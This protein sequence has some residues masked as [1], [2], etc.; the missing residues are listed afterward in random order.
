M[1]KLM[2]KDRLKNIFN[3]TDKKKLF[4]TTVILVSVLYK[5]IFAGGIGIFD[6]KYQVEESS[7]ESVTSEFV[8]KGDKG[9]D[10]TNKKG[11]SM[12]NANENEEIKKISV[13]I[14][15]AVANPGVISLDSD[16]RLDD[17]IRMAGGLLEKADINRI[18]LAVKLEDS[19]HYIIPYVGQDV[20]SAS[21]GPVTQ[22]DGKGNSASGENSKIN[23]N[24][25]D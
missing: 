20:Q 10:K 5:F 4:I 21:E 12:E 1:A 14:T 16:K 9:E 3:E 25:N 11:F 19:Q 13:Y 7:G 23:I 24:D 6:K 18:N 15:G 8:D 17:A 2:L 22:T